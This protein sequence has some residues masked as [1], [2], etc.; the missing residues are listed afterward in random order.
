[1]LNA[2]TACTDR[3]VRSFENNITFVLTWVAG[4]PNTAPKAAKTF[5]VALSAAVRD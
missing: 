4:S 5:A 2:V 1:M 3:F